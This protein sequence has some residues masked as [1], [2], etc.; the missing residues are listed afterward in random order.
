[1]SAVAR[2]YERAPIWAQ[3]LIVSAYG[4]RLRYLRYG[5]AQRE[6]LA[7]LRRSQWLTAAELRQLQLER[8]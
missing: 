8:L 7:S 2:I 3:H 4:V 5:R 1:V 6:Q